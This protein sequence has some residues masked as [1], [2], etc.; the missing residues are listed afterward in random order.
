MSNW[1]WYAIACGVVALLYGVYASR[2]VLAMVRNCRGWAITTPLS[3]LDSERFW[4]DLDIRPLPF[5]GFSRTI[6]LVARRAELGRLPE[7]LASICRD[8][9]DTR[10]V[11]AILEMA[12][13]SEG[14]FTILGREA[15]PA[16]PEDACAREE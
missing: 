12:P 3:V 4:P 1:L 6:H 13:W 5:T 11:P 2:S 8:L 7:R 16:T 9:L 14:A 10:L 15:P